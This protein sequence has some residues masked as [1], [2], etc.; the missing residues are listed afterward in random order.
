MILKTAISLTP[1]P[2]WKYDKKW[3]LCHL[4]KCVMP[5]TNLLLVTGWDEM[6]LHFWK[7]CNATCILLVMG[8]VI[9]MW[10]R[11][12][13]TVC[14][15]QS[16]M[17][18][19]CTSEKCSSLPVYHRVQDECVIQKNVQCL[20]L[21]VGHRVWDGIVIQK[22]CNVT[23]MLVVIKQDVMRQWPLRKMFNVTHILL[24]MGQD[25]MRL[26]LWNMSNVT[27][28]LLLWNSMYH[29]CKCECS[30]QSIGNGTRCDE[31]ENMV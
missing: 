19:D 21:S 12:I 1:S 2:C 8:G 10:F 5:L 3:W 4:E 15:S 26:H 27:H 17:E 11:N 7:M 24:V 20:S 28:S 16:E 9:R 29:D 23:C 25:V 14:M 31:P 30:S 22:M 6:R 13:L 18:W